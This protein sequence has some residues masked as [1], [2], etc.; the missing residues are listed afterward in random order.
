[1]I[2][3]PCRHERGFDD[4]ECECYERGFEELDAMV[5]SITRKLEAGRLESAHVECVKA[6]STR[7]MIHGLSPSGGPVQHLAKIHTLL[8]AIQTAVLLKGTDPVR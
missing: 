2:D 5:I 1:M 4:G 3:R 8:V 7:A 6:L